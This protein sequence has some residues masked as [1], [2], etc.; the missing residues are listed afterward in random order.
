MVSTEFTYHRSSNND[1]HHLHKSEHDHL[2]T[3]IPFETATTAPALFY[4]KPAAAPPPA[5]TEH[6]KFI[7]EIANDPVLAAPASIQ[8][9]EAL[10]RLYVADSP[11]KK[12]DIVVRRTMECVAETVL[13][14]YGY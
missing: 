2:T 3:A 5:T 11:E 7:K 12:C 1:A 13:L 14:L 8:N 9:I 4:D 10:D 6:A